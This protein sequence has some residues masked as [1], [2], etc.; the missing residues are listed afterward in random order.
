MKVTFILAAILL[1]TATRQVKAQQ[2]FKL[3]QF[4]EHNFI[5]NPAAAGAGGN[6]SIG[7]TY[8]KMWNGIDGGPETT[9]LFAD[10][11]LSK[12]KTGI[13]FVLYND[14]TGP[15]ARSGG[16]LCLSY[17]V[18]LSGKQKLMFGLSGQVL[19]ERINLAEVAK[20]IPNDPLLSGPGS[21]I[22]GDAAAGIYYTSPTLSIGVSAKQLVQSKLNFIKSSYGIDARLYRQYYCMGSYRI[23]TDDMDVIM[24]N[25]LVKFAANT[26]LDVEAGARIEHRDILF[27]GFN[28]HFKQDFIAFAGVKIDHKL[29]IGYA[30]DQYKTPLSIFDG[31][32]GASEIMLK[33]S[34]A[35]K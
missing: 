32:G 16:E 14:I 7:I 20:Y 29:Y 26:P 6:T 12:M 4:I 28:F 8:K 15:T 21:V 31:G 18:P 33:Y 34:F 1:A 25:I 35:K 13:G 5:Y 2:I 24:P 10:T 9:I 19:Q 11:Y 3:S 23:R 17:N 22:T 27:M 30:Y